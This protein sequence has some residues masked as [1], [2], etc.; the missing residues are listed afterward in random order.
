MTEL[1]L[2]VDIDICTSNLI[3]VISKYKG[4]YTSL[5]KM[6]MISVIKITEINNE[7]IIYHCFVLFQT[8]SFFLILFHNCNY[9]LVQICTN[10]ENINNHCFIFLKANYYFLM[11][12]Y[13]CNYININL[14]KKKDII[15][16]IILLI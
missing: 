16:N 12:F 2:V 15:L 8:N 10:N 14:H 7:S 13:V 3:L 6:Q 1:D 9:I 5:D 4:K 11:L